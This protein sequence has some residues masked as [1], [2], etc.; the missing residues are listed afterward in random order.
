MVVTIERLAAGGDGV[1]RQGDGRAIFVP[2]TVPGDRVRVRIVEERRRFARAELLEVLQAGPDRT[3]PRCAVFG[4]CGGC[5][6]QH[7][8]YAAQVAAKRSIIQDAL[9]RIG[10]FDVSDPFP[11]TASPNAYAYRQRARVLA[12]DGRLGFRGRRSHELCETAECPVLVPALAR[13]LARLAESGLPGRSDFPA[14][15]GDEWEISAG[16]SGVRTLPLP[17]R[18]GDPAGAM[19]MEVGE[20]RLH[21]SPGVFVQAN[22]LLLGP[23]VRAVCMAALPGREPMRQGDRDSLPSVLELYA[24]AG[25]LTLELA[26]RASSLV[27]V[28]VNP[29]SAAD[30]RRNLRAAG[31][32]NVAVRCE[33]SE[34]VLDLRGALTPDVIVLDPPRAGLG[35]PAVAALAE[36]KAA[37]VVYLSCDPATLARDLAG[38]REHGYRLAHVEGF[39]LFP[40]TAHVEALCV[41]T[42]GGIGLRDSL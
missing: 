27:A 18:R 10:R 35:A 21:I 2:F 17:A 15:G 14:E 3:E 32:Q 31:L 23:L 39:D 33:P 19:E 34:A 12:V 42:R 25:T 1:G 28:E 7:V 26:R 9:R 40:Q 6:W 13:E 11:F 20:D 36:L 22:Q 41:M 30:L 24:G 29:A 37:R 4:R 16:L 8:D 5:S 38:L